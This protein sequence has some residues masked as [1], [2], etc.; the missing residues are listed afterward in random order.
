VATSKLWT[1]E[2]VA[3]LPDDAFRYALIRGVLYRY[4]PRMPRDGRIVA[5]TGRHVSNY[6]VEHR[7]GFGFSGSGFILERNPDT[8]LCPDLSFVR[9]ERMPVDV[10]GY[11]ELAPDLVVEIA[12]PSPSGPSIEEKTAIY[13]AAGVRLIWVVD[14]AR[15]TVSVLR[16][17]G[18]ERLLTEDEVID[19]E[20]VL[21]GFHLPVSQLFA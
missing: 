1:I 16:A 8:L 2:E 6:M 14:P 4:P 17:D 10:D 15:R 7:L 13:L 20:D 21:P 3:Q 9:V 18:N 12:P 11:P 19:G 5:A